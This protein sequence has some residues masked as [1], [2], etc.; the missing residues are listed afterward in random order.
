MMLSAEITLYP[1]QE[2]YRPIIKAFIDQLAAENS[3]KKE[4][5][6]T[7]TVLTGDYD[8]VM[9]VFSRLMKWSYE[10]YGKMVFVV[11]FLP[12]YEAL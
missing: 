12:G 6:P 9:A 2:D 10:K 11:K 3:V 4:T 5:F 8:E 7:S 1:L